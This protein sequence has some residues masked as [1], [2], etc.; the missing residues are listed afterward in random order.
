[1]GCRPRPASHGPPQSL[2][3][4]SLRNSSPKVNLPLSLA[5]RSPSHN[6]AVISTE[7]ARASVSREVEKSASLPRLPP[8][9]LRLRLS[10]C[11]PQRGIGFSTQVPT[12]RPTAASPSVTIH[13]FPLD[14]TPSSF[15]SLRIFDTL[16]P[17]ANPVAV[18]RRTFCAAT[19]PW[20]HLIQSPES[21]CSAVNPVPSDGGQHSY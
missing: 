14:V 5:S 19:N 1:M 16:A 17:L 3:Y 4:L 2:Q 6:N 9:R 13:Q 20:F 11:H 15:Y 12:T 8:G 10:G 7:A 21:F 18:P